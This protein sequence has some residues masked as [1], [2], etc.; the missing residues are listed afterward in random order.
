ME[1][2][3]AYSLMQIPIRRFTKP[4]DIEGPVMF[5]SSDDSNYMIGQAIN[6]DGGVELY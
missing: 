2:I 6:V 4:E 3:K 1:Q 5:L